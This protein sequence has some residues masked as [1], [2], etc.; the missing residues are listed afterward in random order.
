MANNEPDSASPLTR[1]DIEAKIVALAWQD[2][3]FRKK[4]LADPKGQF[5]AHLGTKLPDGLKI[6]AHQEDENQLHF[7]IPV[8]P[9]ANL[10][11]LSDDDLE[12]VAGGIDGVILTLAVASAV[13]WGAGGGVVSALAT[14]KH[15]GWRQ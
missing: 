15:G 5:E 14:E 10:D 13:A 2:D 11:E 6:T 8:K 4:F 3:E 1:Q 12:K 7:V 9:K